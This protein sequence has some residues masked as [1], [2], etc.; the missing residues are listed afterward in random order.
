MAKI[1]LG[2]IAG[3]VSGSIGTQVWS[4]NRFGA[5]IRNRSIPVQP[6]TAPQLAQRA[7]LS[8][9]S[10]IWQDRSAAER[11]SWAVWAQNNPIVDRPG[12]KR[13]LSGHMAYV[14]LNCNIDLID[15]NAISTPPIYAAPT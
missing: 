3:Q 13:I 4:H 1:K 10:A 14:R 9:H 7:M 12:D 2:A 15:E 5:Y 8:L 6:N 11:K